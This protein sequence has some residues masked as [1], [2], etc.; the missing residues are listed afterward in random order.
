VMFSTGPLFAKNVLCCRA[1]HSIV[2]DW[3]G[4]GEIEAPIGV[5]IRK[6]ETKTN[7]TQAVVDSRNKHHSPYAS[8]SLHKL[9]FIHSFLSFTNTCCFPDNSQTTFFFIFFFSLYSFSLFLCFFFFTFF[10][11]LQSRKPIS[12]CSVAGRVSLARIL[13]WQ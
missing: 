13:P 12:E 4:G 1:C 2:G 9:L 6:R 7:T 8:I 3:G 10:A 5:K 11:L